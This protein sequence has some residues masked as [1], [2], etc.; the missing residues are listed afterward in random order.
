MV[1]CTVLSL[2]VLGRAGVANFVEVLNDGEV[3]IVATDRQGAARGQP[4]ELRLDRDGKKSVRVFGR[5]SKEVTSTVSK[6]QVRSLITAIQENRFFELPREVGAELLE[7]GER[8]IV[9]RLGKKENKVILRQLAW[10]ARTSDEGTGYHIRVEDGRREEIDMARRA[11]RVWR[12]IR[13]LIPDPQAYDIPEFERKVL[14]PTSVRIG[15][16]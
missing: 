1:F 11:A 12:A 6:E 9:I 2:A 14:I 15:G 16:R 8:V 7:G 13:A 4:W 3:V 5:S 10:L